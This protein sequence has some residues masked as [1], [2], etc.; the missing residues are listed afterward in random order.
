[1]QSYR[2]MVLRDRPRR[3]DVYQALTGCLQVEIIA[4]S[5]LHVGHSPHRPLVRIDEKGL[6]K[7]GARPSRREVERYIE[8]LAEVAPFHRVSGKLTIPGASVKG[9]VRARLE[10]SFKTRDGAVRS[11][12]LKAGPPPAEPAPQGLQGWRHQRIW[13]HVL[14]EERPACNLLTE[15]VVCLLCDLFGSPGLSSLIHFSDF[16]MING[17]EKIEILDLPYGMRLEAAKP[18]TIFRGSISFRNLRK[19]ELGL[20]L[21]GMGIRNGRTSNPILLGRLKYLSTRSLG[22]RPLG[23]ARYRLNALGLSKLSTESI[24]FNGMELEPGGVV[25]DE[26]TLDQLARC[27]VDSALGVFGSELNLVNEVDVVEQL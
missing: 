12:L 26:K 27:I 16:P 13:Q 24:E 18:G 9:N 21:I 14:H 4:E 8:L 2:V 5:H 10:L 19:E 7:L 22:G 6:Q 17:S 3:R 1:V 11:C 25:L 23:R 20:L 15:G